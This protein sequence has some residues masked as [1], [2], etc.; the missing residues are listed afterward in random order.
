MAFTIN[1]SFKHIF[2]KNL[3]ASWLK[4]AENENEDRCYF[5]Q[6]FWRKNYGVFEELPFHATDDIYYFE[7]SAGL[8]VNGNGELV[9]DP[10]FDRGEILFVPDIT[11]FHKGTPL[12]LFE[13]VNTC[14]VAEEKLIKIRN[15]FTHSLPFIYEIKADDILKLTEP[16]KDYIIAKEVEV[17][18]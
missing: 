11:V 9:F 16:P 6:F 13:I 3:F 7:N 14:P 5:A 17:F 15:F 4:K 10:D 2:A 18:K 8:V 12:L 1:E